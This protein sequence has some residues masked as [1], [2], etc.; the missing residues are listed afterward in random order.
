MLKRLDDIALGKLQPTDFD[1]RYYTHELQEYNRY[2]AL[3]FENANHAQIPEW[4]W[5][6]AHTATLEDFQLHEI[7]E[8][9]NESIRS[10][11]HP[12]VQ[13]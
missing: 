13:K 3:G 8:Y 12:D 2:K 4:V 10:L 6:N 1:L 11:Y 5:D 7:I 9:N